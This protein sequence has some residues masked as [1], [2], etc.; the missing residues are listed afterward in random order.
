MKNIIKKTDVLLVACLLMAAPVLWFALLGNGGASGVS[1]VIRHNGEIL[2]EIGLPRD[3]EVIYFDTGHGVNS[4]LINNYG[5]SMHGADCPD[6]LCLRAAPITRPRSV[7]A[8]LPNRFT[9]EIRSGAKGDD[10][11]DA[12]IQ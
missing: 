9:V 1:A 10:E 11:A 5:V 3:D 7:I 12:V 8:C 4:V 2:L 6:G